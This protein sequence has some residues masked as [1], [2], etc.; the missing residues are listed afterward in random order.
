MSSQDFATN[1]TKDI[2][3]KLAA[4]T[5]GP[6]ADKVLSVYS[7]DDFHARSGML[8]TPFC[9]VLYAGLRE[10]PGGDVSGNSADLVVSILFG[11]A[12]T[13]KAG[14]SNDTDAWVILSKS[15]KAIRKTRSPTGHFWRFSSEA[16]VG[17]EKKIAFFIQTWKTWA[18]LLGEQ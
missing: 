10:A 14:S 8:S 16:Y 9:G 7:E 11:F 18:A 5:D 2:V 15:R 4:L 1:C 17:N 6:L 12:S 3:D 13:P